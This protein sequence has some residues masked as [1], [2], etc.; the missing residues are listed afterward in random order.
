[1]EYFCFHYVVPMGERYRFLT[2]CEDIEKQRFLKL[3]AYVNKLKLYVRDE[4]RK[5]NS[6]MKKEQR[7][8]DELG[9]T[10]KDLTEG[11]EDLNEKHS[12]LKEKVLFA[13]DELFWKDIHRKHV[14]EDITALK[15]TV[16]Y[17]FNC[18]TKIFFN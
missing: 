3:R 9:E 2:Y 18:I 17:E 7:N 1:M 16:N 5:L 12:N 14:K 4:E 10:L 11:C 6:R 15:V 13:K 8:E